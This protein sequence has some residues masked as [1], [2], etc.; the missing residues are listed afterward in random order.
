MVWVTLLALLYLQNKKQKKEAPHQKHNIININLSVCM[1]SCTCVCVHVFMYMCSYTCVC[2]QVCWTATITW[3]LW[4]MLS[5]VAV[6]SSLS[7]LQQ[8][9]NKTLSSHPHPKVHQD[10]GMAA[11]CFQIESPHTSTG[12]SRVWTD[13]V[14]GPEL[15]P[16]GGLQGCLDY[17]GTTY[18]SFPNVHV[19]KRRQNLRTK[20]A[21]SPAPPTLCHTYSMP[22][23]MPVL[24]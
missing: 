4:D 20:A 10:G 11:S 21:N 15:A 14:S 17:R 8:Q 23:L 18:I 5:N 19:L 6:R 3:F 7:E 16:Q 24:L 1:C 9:L 12:Y 22:L 2:V 13:H